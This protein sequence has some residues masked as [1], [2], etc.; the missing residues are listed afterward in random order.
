MRSSGKGATAHNLPDFLDWRLQNV[1][2]QGIW[3]R[4]ADLFGREGALCGALRRV[5]FNGAALA[6]FYEVRHSWAT[7]RHVESY[8][9]KY[10]NVKVAET[11][12]WLP[13][14]A[15]QKCRDVEKAGEALQ[16]TLFCV[17]P[18]VLDGSAAAAMHS[19]TTRNNGGALWKIRIRQPRPGLAGRVGA[20]YSGTLCGG[21]PA[22]SPALK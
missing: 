18:I 19:G 21:M 4:F 6:G 22:A 15:F 14:V 8:S 2:L 12:I 10:D 7:L 17:V 20:S 9:K 13:Q 1:A 5:R 3:Q 16:S 11:V